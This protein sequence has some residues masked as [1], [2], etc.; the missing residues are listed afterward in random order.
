MSNTSRIKM[1]SF[2]T[3]NL[4][5]DCNSSVVFSTS[6]NV[7]SSCCSRLNVFRNKFCNYLTRYEEGM[8]CTLPAYLKHIIPIFLPSVNNLKAL[9]HSLTNCLLEKS[10]QIIDLCKARSTRAPLSYNNI[11]CTLHF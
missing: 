4:Q 8:T 9:S 7:I 5:L 3:L 2:L 11:T 10:N 1:C 6:N